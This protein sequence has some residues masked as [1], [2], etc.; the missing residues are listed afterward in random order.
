MTIIVP[1]FTLESATQRFAWQKT[2]GT[3]A[4]RKVSLATPDSRWDRSF[5][6]GRTGSW[7]SSPES[8][9]RSSTVADR[10]GLHR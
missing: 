9:Q 4:I 2:D 5:A 1:P 10:V 7:R 6:N 8:G 3:A